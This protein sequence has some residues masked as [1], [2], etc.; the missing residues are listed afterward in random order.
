MDLGME[1]SGDQVPTV[2]PKYEL[3]PADAIYPGMFRVRALRDIPR[4]KV[5]AGDEGGV[6]AGEGN[7][8]QEGDC[9]RRRGIFRGSDSIL[10]QYGDNARLS[11]CCGAGGRCGIRVFKVRAEG[12]RPMGEAQDSRDIR[13]LSYG[14]M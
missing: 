2:S 14:S 10:P 7:L 1:S 12:H 11:P 13:I 9:R 8:S 5:H 6:I 4:Y 3:I